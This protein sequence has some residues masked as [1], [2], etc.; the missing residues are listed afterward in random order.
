MYSTDGNFQISIKL[1]IFN[2]NSGSNFSALYCWIETW[3]ISD[4]FKGKW[5][6][7]FPPKS[8]AKNPSKSSNN[9]SDLICDK[10]KTKNLNSVLFPS[11][12][13]YS[14]YLQNIFW[15]RSCFSISN[16]CFYCITCTFPIWVS[17]L[18]D[19]SFNIS[20]QRIVELVFV[21]ALFTLL[22]A[23]NWETI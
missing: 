18:C 8:F 23:K 17:S 14:E 5:L 1:V 3:P 20:V 11:V 10:L 2:T 19:C 16:P 7:Q 4:V 21:V 15:I 13:Q 9:I 6:K 22:L 12:K